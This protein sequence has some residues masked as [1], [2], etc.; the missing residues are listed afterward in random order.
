MICFT[1]NFLEIQLLH[2]V[3]YLGNLIKKRNKFESQNWYAIKKMIERQKHLGN[4]ILL[5]IKYKQVKLQKEWL[6]DLCVT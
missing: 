6:Q 4:K 1:L 3:Q 2:E 5:A